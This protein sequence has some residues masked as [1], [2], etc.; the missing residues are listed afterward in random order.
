MNSI[1]Q[2]KILTLFEKTYFIITSKNIKALFR[3]SDRT[4]RQLAQKL[5]TSGFLK[6]ANKSQKAR[7]YSSLRT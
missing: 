4:A 5:V 6:I 2:K 1:L 7:K 3:F